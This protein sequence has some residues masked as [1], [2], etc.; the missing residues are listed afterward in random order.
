[1]C[2]NHA[3]PVF[4]RDVMYREDTEEKDRAYLKLYDGHDWNWFRVSLS[5][6]DM[7]YLRKNWAGKKAAAPVL[8]KRHRKYFLRFSYTEEVLLTKA[9]AK[10]QIICSVDLGLNTDAVCTIMRSDGTVLG[11]KFINFLSEKDR[12]YRVLG[13]IS[14]FQRK[15]GS[16]QVK[17]R[18]AYAKRLNTELGRKIAGAVTGYAEENH[19]DVIVFEYLETKGKISGRKKQKLHLWRKGIS[20]KDVNIRLTGEGCGYPGSVHGIPAGLHMMGQEQLS[21]IRAITV[22]VHSRM[23]KDI[24]VIFRRP[25]I[26]EQDILYGN[27]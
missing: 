21:V 26:L 24:T 5:H 8:E 3:M 1:M 13:R 19:A 23:E 12:M 11:R 10:E 16:V 27:S 17:S 6:T 25:I 14:R 20:R 7:E 4:Y 15:H 2:G 18:W 22:S 9:A